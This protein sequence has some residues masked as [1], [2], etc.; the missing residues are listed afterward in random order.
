ML[1]IIDTCQGWVILPA[2]HE[3]GNSAILCYPPN[4]GLTFFVCKSNL[5]N[6]IVLLWS[7]LFWTT[8]DCTVKT[9][10]L[11]VGGMYTFVRKAFSCDN[12]NIS[13]FSIKITTLVSISV[14]IAMYCLLQLYFP[15][16]TQLAPKKPI[17]KLVAIK[18]VGR[19]PFR[20]FSDLIIID[21]L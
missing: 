3:M 14:S 20:S 19:Y 5:I 7:P 18:A 2:D 8:L 17:L 16:S 11:R 12:P 6:F 13:E 10:G 21:H 1:S 15:V 9:P 4:V